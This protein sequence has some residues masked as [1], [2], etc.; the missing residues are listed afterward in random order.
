MINENMLTYIY[1]VIIL[2][3][4][5]VIIATVRIELFSF[6]S[7]YLDR[8]FT[9]ID[10]FII[11]REKDEQDILNN[12]VR[13]IAEAKDQQSRDDILYNLPLNYRQKID[14][15]FEQTGY[16][17]ACFQE[18]VKITTLPTGQQAEYYESQ[19]EEVKDKI[20]RYLKI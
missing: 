12:I 11:S 3:C 13:R 2:V 19:S 16:R 6:L 14:T 5:I 10:K 1:V 4:V 20:C 9:D 17:I 8:K 18:F 7:K 15:L